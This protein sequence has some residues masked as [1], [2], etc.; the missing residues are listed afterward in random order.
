MV[1][2]SFGAR[3]EL[4]AFC[5]SCWGGIGCSLCWLGYSNV[6]W[7]SASDRENDAPN[8]PMKRILIPKMFRIEVGFGNCF[9]E[10]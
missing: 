9:I 3:Q 1:L 7:D 2:F 4:S 5:S 8:I 10:L 6:S